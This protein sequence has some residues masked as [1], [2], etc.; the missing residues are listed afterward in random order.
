MRF[1]AQNSVSDHFDMHFNAFHKMFWKTTRVF[2]IILPR[3]IAISLN[4]STK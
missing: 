4:T 1:H 2:L 3:N